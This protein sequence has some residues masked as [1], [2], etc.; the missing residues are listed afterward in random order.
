[1]YNKHITVDKKLFFMCL[2]TL[3][4]ILIIGPLGWIISEL[5]T[6]S[7]IYVEYTKNQL[8]SINTEIHTLHIESAKTYLTKKEFSE[9]WHNYRKEIEYLDS[10]IEDKSEEK[11]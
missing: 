1:M 6:A 10:K 11:H 2:I 5:W 9:F 3:I 4:N 7:K 8:S